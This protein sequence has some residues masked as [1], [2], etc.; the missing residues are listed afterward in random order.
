M[1]EYAA[2]KLERA[3]ETEAVERR[4]AEYYRDQCLRTLPRARYRLD[5]WLGWMDSEIDNIRAVLQRCD[6]RV[7]LDIV[8]FAG[9]YW[10]TRATGEGIRWLDEL[11]A[12][13]PAPPAMALFTRG[14]LA[15]LTADLASARPALERA[16]ED[17][18]RPGLAGLRVQALSLA[19]IAAHGTG[20]APAASALLVTAETSAKDLDD[21]PATIACLQARA[22][23]GLHDNDLESTRAA[24]V[25]GV[26]LS[27]HAGDLYA[28]EMMLMN[29]GT[30]HLIG[31]DLDESKPLLTESL[32]IARRID[33]RV[34]QYA[35]L[36][37][38]ACHAAGERRPALAAQLIGAAET[39]QRGVG[40]TMIPYIG[41]LIAQAR[42]ST[43]AALGNAAFQSRSDAGRDLSRTAA[44]QL[45][46]GE[47]VPKP[48]PASAEPLSKREAEVARLIADGLRNKEIAARLLI[49]EY[50]V[51][52]HVRSVLA[53]LGFRSRAEVA[54]WLAAAGQSAT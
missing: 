32:R 28:L 54:A 46:L 14:F 26:R 11:L 35:L 17:A 21:Y 52:S 16:A 10:V 20:D 50:T 24:A 1:R 34:A 37:V 39:L 47:S 41:P 31:G 25:E 18:H 4:C 3:G 48:A 44:I 8:T 53:K 36:D 40:A 33:D 15:V 5:E 27:R 30:A 6:R 12:G 45:A 51:D 22:L 23:I 43:R 7:G 13:D 19:A 9:W 49:S 2:L 42:D 38:L 29:L